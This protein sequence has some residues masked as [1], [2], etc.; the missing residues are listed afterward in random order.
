MHR[1]IPDTR[2]GKADMSLYL[3]L[4]AGF[5]LLLICGDMLV[6]GAVATA[7]RLGM[8]S[9]LIGVV[10]VGF[11][12]SMPEMVTSVEA[13]LAGSPGIAIGNIVGSNLAN[14]L[15]VL[16]LSA[17][18]APIAIPRLAARR[19]GLVLLAA[20]LL[21]VAISFF[22]SLDRLTG[23]GLFL[24]L[25]LYIWFAYQQ[26]RKSIV[27]IA[28]DV[29]ARANELDPKSLSS[30]VAALAVRRQFAIPIALTLAG[31]VVLI[32]GGKLLVDGARGIALE[33][34]VSETIIGLTIVAIGTSL[35]EVVTCIIAALRRHGDV[36]LGNVL[37]SS[38]YN[39]LAI[40]GVTAIISPTVIPAEIVRFDNL[41]MLVA[42]LT[43][44]LFLFFGARIGRVQGALLAAS[45][46]GYLVWIWP[47]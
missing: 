31:L 43:L 46:A 14:I 24:G 22:S 3:M 6:R 28:S 35:P 2:E 32:V 39:L 42:T 17:L 37:G 41:V 38:V 12:T 9:L 18:A 21:F 16:G 25:T 7:E 34:G 10:V 26:E 23:A 27:P 40:G 36:A 30:D 20:T 45:Y 13:S 1:P 15:L 11:G 44:L 4:A 33:A 5:V 8:S 19:D 47:T 29:A